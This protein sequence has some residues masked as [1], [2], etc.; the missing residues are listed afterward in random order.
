MRRVLIIDDEAVIR[1]VAALSLELAGW[2]VESAESGPQ[3]VS[4]AREVPPDV[5]LLD[6]MMPDWD[7][8]TT[9]KALREDAATRRLPVVFLSGKS[10]PAE[11]QHLLALGA[12]GVIAKPFDPMTLGEQL[13]R[14]LRAKA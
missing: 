6:V 12:T 2:Q 5:V 13:G 14:L 3:G 9:L 1:E 7:G 4:H 11:Q 10:S 8:P